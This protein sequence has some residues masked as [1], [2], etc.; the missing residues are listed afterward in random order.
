MNTL[1]DLPQSIH[2]EMLEVESSFANWKQRMFPNWN[3]SDS[4][5]NALLR[6]GME[7]PISTEWST[8]LEFSIQN[9]VIRWLS[10]SMQALTIHTSRNPSWLE[11]GC[12]IWLNSDLS[13]SWSMGW[14][15]IIAGRN[16]TTSAGRIYKT[17]L[18]DHIAWL[19]ALNK[20]YPQ[21]DISKLEFS[22]QVQVGKAVPRQSC[23]IRTSI[24]SISSCGCHDNRVDKHWWNEQWMG[25][26][27]GEHYK[28]Q[29]NITNANLLEETY[30]SSR[31]N[32]H[33]CSSWIHIPTGKRID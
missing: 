12:F 8:G 4:L 22:E 10:I 29:S 5:T 2:F 13:R 32:G 18:P 16:F 25:F 21:C 24:Q 7:R 9:I 23:I 26:P 3:N 20:A 1:I 19:K 28:D 27:I 33:Q 17:G 11:W 30:Y 15:Q 6:A 31:R 14:A